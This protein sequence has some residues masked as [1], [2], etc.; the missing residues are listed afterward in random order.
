M[1]TRG[2]SPWIEEAIESILAQT[3]GAWRLVVS[4]NSEGSP[5]CARALA[6]YLDDPRITHHVT[7][8]D[9]GLAG[10]LTGLIRRGTAPYVALLHDDDRWRPEFLER[11]VA[12]L[13]AHPGCGLV[14]GHYVT[15]DEAGRKLDVSPPRLEP[16]EHAPAEMLPV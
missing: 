2:R 8:R 6:P 7:G 4:E 13:D 9:L 1:P 5:E 15:I 16:G 10:N 12:F 11:R 3:F 14:F